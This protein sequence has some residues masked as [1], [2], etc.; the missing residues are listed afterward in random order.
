MSWG[1]TIK[2][3]VH[4]IYAGQQLE[5]FDLANGK[6]IF[7]TSDAKEGLTFD[8]DLGTLWTP[9]VPKK[10]L[11]P[12][13]LQYMKPTFAFVARNLVDEGFVVKTNIVHGASEETAKFGTTLR[14]G[15]EVGTPEALGV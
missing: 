2:E 7:E 8:A 5:A 1:T 10:V 11:P 12:N 13:F 4:R 3:T 9:S 15:L 14:L 6:H